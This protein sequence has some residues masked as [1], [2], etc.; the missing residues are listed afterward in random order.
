MPAINERVQ[1][2]QIQPKGPRPFFGPKPVAEP[3][4]FRPF[5]VQPKLTIGRPNDIYEKE[6][7]SM[8]D[9]VVRMSQEVPQ[10]QKDCAE[11]EKK[12]GLQMK[13]DIQ[14][15]AEEEEEPLQTK[16]ELQRQAEEE[17]EEPLQT[18]LDVQPQAEE[19]EE[20]PLQAKR[21][22]QRQAE[23]EEEEPVQAKFLQLKRLGSN[24]LQ[25]SSQLEERLNQSKSGGQSLPGNTNAFMSKAFG[26]DFSGVRVH[27][28][29]DAVQMN[30]DLGAKAFTN[31]SD[32]YF[33]KGQYNPESSEGK[34]LLAHE[35]T[36]VV[37]QGEAEKE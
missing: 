28:G 6:A 19:E 13:L 22:I 35:L 17:E 33:N 7:D 30:Q 12:K 31:G 34:H 11:C 18:K 16:L 36:H 25:A 4:F 23:E 32:V 9:R 29:S 27:T 15:Q 10:V 26:R 21:D 37:Q 8:A 3:G 14:R 24:H 5:T 20:E 2:T 1:Q